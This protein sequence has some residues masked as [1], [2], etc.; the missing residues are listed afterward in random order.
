MMMGVLRVLLVD[1]EAEVRRVARRVLERRGCEV[2]EAD[3]GA[4]A[5]ASV[6]N[7]ADFD[8][9]VADLDMPGMHGSE[10]VRRLRLLKDNFSVLYLTAYIDSLMDSRPLMNDEAFLEKPFSS[11]GLVEAVSLLAFDTVH[12]LP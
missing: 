5:L 6:E 9:L 8:L 1:D 3:C 11:T 12:G 4:A 2:A 7:G 10:M